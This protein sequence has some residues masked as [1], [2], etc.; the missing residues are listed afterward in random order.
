[1]KKLS[2]VLLAVLAISFT[3]C[4]NWLNI[5]PEPEP[6]P[7]PEPDP[8]E[9]SLI[10]LTTTSATLH[11]GETFQIVAE[12]E[13]PIAYSSENEY[14]AMVSDS[15]LV[16]AVFVG[17]TMINL[18]SEYDTQTFEVTVEP[19]SDLYPEPDI[20]IGETK[21]AI[22]EKFGEP[23]AESDDAVI[24]EDYSENASMLMVMFDEEGL[25]E[26]YA[27]IL[28]VSS[29][30]E[31]D[32]FLS[33]RYMFI[34]EEEEIKIYMNGLDIST[35]TMFIGSQIVEEEYMMAFY[36]AN[37]EGGEEAVKVVKTLKSLGK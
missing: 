4:Q 20:E 14:H 9:E 31:L 11:S 23:G 21:D 8:V 27:V 37:D 30:E 16:T 35:A 2:L 22:I 18:E 7:E 5:D 28:D 32:T 24:F 15:G 17:S 3:G 10:T 25:V 13:S 36:M 34:G 33:E 29:A 12:C 26:A 19:V 1:M 6:E